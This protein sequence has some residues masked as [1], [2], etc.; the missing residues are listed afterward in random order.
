MI[1]QATLPA[2]AGTLP[3]HGEG[4]LILTGLAV[5]AL[6]F[7]GLGAWSAVAPLSGAVMVNG[8]VAVES[9]RK[10][11]QHL[12]GGIVKRI[13]VKP[14]SIV[15]QGEPLLQLEDVQANAAVSTT[16]GQRDAELARGARLAAERAFSSRI[17]FPSELSARLHVPSVAQ[18]IATEQKLFDARR[19]SI[20]DQ[21]ALLRQVNAGIQD[22]IVSLDMQVRSA[23]SGL[24]N[25]RQQLGLNEQLM[26]EKFVSQARVLEF[27][28]RVSD[29]ALQRAQAGAAVAQVR[30]K[31]KQNELRIEGLRQDYVKGAADEL[32]SA[33]QRIEE[34]RERLRPNEDALARLTVVAPIAG[35]VVDLKVHTV[36]GVVAPREPLMSIVPA[37]AP[38]VVKGKVHTEDITHLN[39]GAEVAIQL[40]AYKR[41]TT[42]VVMGRL[43]YISADMLTEQTSAG[44]APYYEVRIS[45][46]KSALEQAGDLAI[47]PGMPVEAYVR[48]DTRTLLEYLLQPLTQAVRRAGRQS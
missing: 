14:G 13:L 46:E 24:D 4:R 5:I 16:R 44:S 3:T 17:A 23:D 10:I 1:A 47:V 40:V 31:I 19:Q 25:A 38:L 21:I 15:T 39:L 22:E 9:E 36:G 8:H 27:Q 12:E 43:S 18:I 6:T 48:T 35:E 37:G 20:D 41:R 34:L 26:H 2:P 28:G 30:Q 42:P 32:R 29:R 11:V 45:V 7:G 33:E